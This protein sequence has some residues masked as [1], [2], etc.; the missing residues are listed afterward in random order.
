MCQRCEYCGCKGLLLLSLSGHRGEVSLD[1]GRKQK[2]FKEQKRTKKNKDEAV[3]DTRIALPSTG[4]IAIPDSLLQS[5]MMAVS[6]RH[7]RGRWHCYQTQSSRNK[8]LNYYSFPSS[9]V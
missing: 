5:L 8:I 7:G 1:S 3:A 4:S 2:I 9:L 6:Y